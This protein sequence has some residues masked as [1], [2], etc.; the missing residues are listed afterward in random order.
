MLQEDQSQASKKAAGFSVGTSYNLCYY[1]DPSDSTAPNKDPRGIL[2]LNRMSDISIAAKEPRRI[3][4][5]FEQGAHVVSL[6]ADSRSDA[7]RWVFGLQNARS[8]V[9]QAQRRLTVEEVKCTNRHRKKSRLVM[10]LKRA[11]KRSWTYWE[12]S[13]FFAYLR[14]VLCVII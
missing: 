9:Q 12:F 7:D 8:K 5:S 11:R 3:D 1:D 6:L 10:K 2:P 4:I 14:L 13:Y